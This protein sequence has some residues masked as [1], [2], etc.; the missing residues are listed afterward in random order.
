M[1]K[2]NYAKVRLDDFKTFKIVKLNS[3]IE[4]DPTKFDPKEEI[5]LFYN[6]ANTNYKVQVY[7]IMG[8]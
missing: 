3:L 7:E 4:F 8:N 2:K 1:D 5:K 6:L